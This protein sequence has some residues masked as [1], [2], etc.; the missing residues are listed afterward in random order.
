MLIEGTNQMPEENMLTEFFI[1]MDKP[2]MS[3]WDYS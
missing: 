1:I 3:N 2:R